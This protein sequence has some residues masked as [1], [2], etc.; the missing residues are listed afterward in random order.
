MSNEPKQR[1][2]QE[3]IKENG[4]LDLP[5][6]GED[7]NAFAIL[8]RFKKVARRAGWD[9]SDIDEVSHMAQSSDYNH[10]L[11]VISQTSNNV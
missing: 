11:N 5:L 3:I 10:L 7:G 4:K 8:G 6:V 9:S 1:R 2:L